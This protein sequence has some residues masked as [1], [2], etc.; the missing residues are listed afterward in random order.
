MAV[1]RLETVID[2][3]IERCFDLARSIDLHTVS[4]T[5]QNEKAIS[6]RTSGLIELGEEVT[7]EARHF[8]VT[9][10]LTSKIT[11]YDRPFRFRDSMVQGAFQRFDHDHLFEQRD[12]GT[13]MTDAFDYNAPLGILGIIAERL[14]LTR[15]MRNL[16]TGRNEVIQRV[17]ESDEWRRILESR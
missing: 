13:L 2:A 15:Y 17:A 4:M 7:W 9:Q 16:L 5:T 3:P 8:G 12:T 6:G 11:A 14:F 1:I 10:Q